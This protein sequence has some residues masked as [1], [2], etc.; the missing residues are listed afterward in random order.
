MVSL[1]FG[2]LG[3]GEIKRRPEVEML[4]LTRDIRPFFDGGDEHVQAPCRFLGKGK[5]RGDLRLTGGG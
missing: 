3:A 1:E 5:P 4:L 2:G